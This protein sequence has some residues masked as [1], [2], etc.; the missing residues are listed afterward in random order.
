M[1][2]SERESDLVQASRDAWLAA[3]RAQ[4]AGADPANLGAAREDGLKFDALCWPSESGQLIAASAADWQ[5]GE[6]LDHPDP[7]AA[8]RL[9]VAAGRVL[10]CLVF[11]GAPCA[12]GFG[13]ADDGESVDGLMAVLPADLSGIRIEPHPSGSDTVERIVK[14]LKGTAPPPIRF[15]LD[16][17]GNFARWGAATSNWPAKRAQLAAQI[18]GLKDRGFTGPFL[19]A[20]GRVYHEGGATGCQEL[21]AILATAVFYRELLDGNISGSKSGL[22]AI[23][24]SLS[25]PANQAQAIA[26]TRAARLLWARLQ[27]LCGDEPRPA[28]IHGET[29]WPMMARD[30]AHTNIIRTTIAALAAGVAGA[31]SLSILPFSIR[32]GL[33]DGFSRRIARNTHYLLKEEAHIQFSADPAAG[34]GAYDALTH[35][36]AAK[37]WSLFQEIQAEGGIVESLAAGAFHGRIAAAVDRRRSDLADGRRI[38]VGITDFPVPEPVRD[39]VEAVDSWPERSVN[40]PAI[41]CPALVPVSFDEQGLGDRNHA[42]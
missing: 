26:K 36:M 25:I 32:N 19:E 28:C 5:I 18:T 16:P 12:H 23:G 39:H 38:L 42:A 35:A 13:V 6:R 4:L 30:D 15:G 1:A 21:A 40:D 41:R 2:Y 10:A 17:I 37:T 22:E 20:D 31:D 34:S 3:A 11:A 14:S 9:G 8:G 24:M 27:D 29:S 7:R 33:P